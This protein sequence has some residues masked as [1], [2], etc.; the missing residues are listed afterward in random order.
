MIFN[1]PIS[2]VFWCCIPFRH[3]DILKFSVIGCFCTS[4]SGTGGDPLSFKEI[5]R[6]LTTHHKENASKFT[7]WDRVLCHSNNFLA[8]FRSS[9]NRL[10]LA[11]A[12]RVM[13]GLGSC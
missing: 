13:D 7:V 11:C 6:L 1:S 9:N 5:T 3:G 12:A 2:F 8:S 10:W 4:H